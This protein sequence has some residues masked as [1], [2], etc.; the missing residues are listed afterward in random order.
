MLPRTIN[1]FFVLGLL[2]L[3]LVITA[4]SMTKPISHDEQMYCTGAALLAQG[5]MIYKD[6]S[7][8]THLPYHPAV[9]AAIFKIFNTT[10]YLLACR[11]FSVACDILTIIV[12]AFTYCLVLKCLPVAAKLLGLAAAAVYVFNPVV[13]YANGFAWNHDMVLLCVALAFAL[14][15]STDFKQK[16]KYRRVAVIGALLALASWTRM[17]TALVYVVFL[18]ALL[19]RPADSLK[20]R[21]QTVLP[22]LIASVIVSIWPLYII[23]LA[24]KAFML[25]IFVIPAFN[26][27]WQQQVARSPGVSEVLFD[28]LARPAYL[29]LFLIAAYFCITLALL[30]RKITKTDKANALLSVLLAVVFFVIIF[31]PPVT[32]QQYFAMPALFIIISFAYPLLYLGRLLKTGKTKIHFQIAS[33]VIAVCTIMTVGLNLPVLQR[34]PK[35]FKPQSWP[36]VLLHSISEDIAQRV[37][38]PKRILTLAP[39]YAL[40][41]GCEIYPQFSAGSFVY[42]IADLMTQESLSTVTGAGFKDIKALVEDCPPSAVIIGTEPQFLEEPLFN[43]AVKPHWQQKN[44]ASGLVVFF[45]P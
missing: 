28:C 29:G 2:V 13:D 30:R 33:I 20:Q 7:Y 16:S 15:I 12:I 23:A 25:N 10:H 6:F 1:I 42:R 17:T 41:G 32:F 27:E 5:K 3:S 19:S 39:L 26:G 31:I 4:D 21:W 11:L 38:E 36:P 14:F 8:V 34:V 22:F 24:P 35:L 45:E 43:A 37:K 9:C 44:Y 18:L 40:E